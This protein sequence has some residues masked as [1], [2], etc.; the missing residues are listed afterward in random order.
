MLKKDSQWNWIDGYNVSQEVIDYFSLAK[1]KEDQ[2]RKCTYLNI[3][4]DGNVKIELTN[5][6]NEKQP[7]ICKYG[8]LFEIFVLIF[9]F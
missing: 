7:Y 8:K 3:R 6:Q 9:F 4:D 2:Y 5:C 1:L